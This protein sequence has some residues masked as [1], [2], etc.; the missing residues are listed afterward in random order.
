MHRNLTPGTQNKL[1]GRVLSGAVLLAAASGLMAQ[2]ADQG[3]YQGPGISSPGVGTIG[4]R[5]GEQ[6]DLRFYL[7]VSGVV[8]STLV[9][10]SS[11]AQGNLIRIP[12][13]YGIEVTG[14][15][16]GTHSWKRSQLG[17]NYVGSYTRYLNYDGYNSNNHSLSLGYT[18]QVSRRLKVDLRESAGSLS[19]G[20]VQVANA[21]SID[22]NSSFTPAVRLFDTR[23][24]F[25]QS[26]ASATYLQSSRMSYTVG[27]TGFLQNLKSLG[28][29][30]GWGYTFNGNMMRR[31]S[32]SASVGL[33]Y[34]Y[35]HFEFPAFFSR[36]D[37]HTFHGVYDTALGRFWT[38]SIEA[39]VTLTRGESLVT[40]AL[41]PVLAAL[42]RQ[43][44]I[45]GISSLRTIYPSGTVA[46]RRQFR[47]ASL[48]FNYFR[49]VNS[50]N[51]FYTTG[52][53][54]NARA[55][56]SYTG[57]RK[58]NMG[59]DGGYYD[60]RSIGQNLGNYTQYLAGAGVSYALG[61]DIHLSVRYDFRN[62]RIDS[63]N[64]SP[65]GFRTTIGLNFS[66]GSLPLSLW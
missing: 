27:A 9:P 56:F 22:L 41:N 14:G 5:S 21:A 61:R 36:S 8:D 13:L 32:R 48:G 63:S 28:L 29:S 64:Y 1:L 17:L 60:L 20:A 38:L 65:N 18:N 35:S 52:R 24:Y 50:G 37:S 16:Y 40:V 31:V 55:S 6:V 51:G 42:L 15:A 12:N 57:L 19:Y 54:N 3:S 33:A 25:L 23:T 26:S 4:S 11:D 30:N 43:S 2:D 39:G 10:F 66:P 45:T 44:T 46:L 62:Q 53:L 58:I 34:E 49:G 47:R 7:G 59:V